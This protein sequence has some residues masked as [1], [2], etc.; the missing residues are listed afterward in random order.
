MRSERLSRALTRLRHGRFYFNDAFFPRVSHHDTY[1]VSFPRSGNTWLRCLLTTLIT[2]EPVS[3]DLIQATVPDV[4]N[5]RKQ[6]IP[7]PSIQPLIIKTHSP[8]VK[9]P[10]KIIYLVRDGRDALVSF[11]HYSQQAQDMNRHLSLSD[12]FFHPKLWPAPWHVHTANWL[13]GLAGWDRRRYLLI[14]YEDLLESPAVYLEQIARFAAIPAD[15]A[16]IEQAVHLNTKDRLRDIEQ[17]AGSGSLNNISTQAYDNIRA[18]LSPA[19]WEAYHRLAG[20]V[21]ERLGYQ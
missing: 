7:K 4:Y 9:I 18:A 8:Y 2:S 19:E 3:P 11:Y 13:D 17:Q 1:L 5:S 14:R 20:T 16:R 6:Q 10:A 12:F 21:L 15:S